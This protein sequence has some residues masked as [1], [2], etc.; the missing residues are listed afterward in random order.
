MA[1]PATILL[2]ED[3]H[4]HLRLTRR[5]LERSGLKA[6]VLVARDGKEALS[7]LREC[8]EGNVPDLVL[9]DLNM[10]KVS[11]REVLRAMKADPALAGVPVVVISSSNRE[12]DSSLARALG[13]AGFICKAGGFEQLTKDLSTLRCYLPS[14]EPPD[15]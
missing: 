3:N 1:L 13:A 2:V 12:E 11:G 5:I 9:L 6:Q 4:D 15:Q 10:P 7:L 8:K 14:E